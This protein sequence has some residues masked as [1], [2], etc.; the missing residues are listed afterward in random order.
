MIFSLLLAVVALVLVHRL[1]D[2]RVRHFLDRAT[3]EWI[4]VHDGMEDEQ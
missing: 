1:I 4:D 2:R 3:G